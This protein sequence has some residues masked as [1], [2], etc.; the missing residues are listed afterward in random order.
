M[1]KVLTMYHQIIKKTTY[2]L[3]EENLPEISFVPSNQKNKLEKLTTKLTQAEAV[4]LYEEE[5]HSMESCYPN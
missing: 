2:S 4:K 1:E 5:L 3:V